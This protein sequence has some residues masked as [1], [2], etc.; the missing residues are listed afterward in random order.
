MIL[1]HFVMHF[2]HSLAS[3]VLELKDKIIDFFGE[4]LLENILDPGEINIFDF[5]LKNKDFFFF[6]VN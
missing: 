6:V 1:K 5:K 2:Q 3:L 4:E